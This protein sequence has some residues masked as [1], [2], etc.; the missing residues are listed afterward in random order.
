MNNR[1]HLKA[2]V[3]IWMTNGNQPVDGANDTRYEFCDDSWSEAAHR[4]EQLLADGMLTNA[5]GGAYMENT[6]TFDLD[7]WPTAAGIF[8]AIS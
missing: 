3:A 8:E 7:V 5:S 2:I 6:E 4:T 1:A